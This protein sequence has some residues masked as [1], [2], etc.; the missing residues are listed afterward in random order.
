MK[1]IVTVDGSDIVIRVPVKLHQ[2]L[3]AA[4]DLF[5]DG[6]PEDREGL[7]ENEAKVV[8]V[9]ENIIRLRGN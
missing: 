8:E 7:T 2:E 3:I 5:L 6:L 1:T 9:F 4:L